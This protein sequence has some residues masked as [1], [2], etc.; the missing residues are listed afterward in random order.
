M[1]AYHRTRMSRIGIFLAECL[2]FL[3]VTAAMIIASEFFLRW[4]YR[5]ILTSATGIDYFYNHSYRKFAKEK[6][7][8]GIRGKHFDLIGK[9]ALRVVVMG[10]S[11]TY[12]QGVYPYDKRFPEQAAVLFSKKYPGV[13]VEFVN[14]GVCGADLPQYNKNILNFITA[15]HPDFVLYQ[16]FINDMDAAPDFIHTPHMIANQKLHHFLTEN[17]V[18]Y[19]VLQR[20]WKQL[21]TTLGQ[22]QTYHEYL[23]EKFADSES[24]PS[25][26]ARKALNMLLEQLDSK[27]IAHGI[28]LFPDFSSRQ[29]EYKLAFL[30]EQVLKVCKDRQVDCL[31]LR[32]AYSKYDG[33]IQS[34]WANIFDHHPSALAHRVAAEKIVDFFG[35]I[36]KKM[37]LRRYSP[38]DKQ[39]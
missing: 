26:A 4:Y 13:D 28:V 39:G 3:T 11:F 38:N 29:S 1:S 6:N 25:L 21:R 31:D 19:F 36:W 33:N 16:W 30:H 10:D 12:G 24:A 18:L 23:A 15:L 9:H 34:L 14:V 37:T 22:K 8:L 7:A 32:D 27:N 2:L 5:D 17:S 35:E 20:G